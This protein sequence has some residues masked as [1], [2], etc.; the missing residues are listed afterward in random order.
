MSPW[1]PPGGIRPPAGERFARE[2]G[3]VL[4]GGWELHAAQATEVLLDAIARSDG[5]RAS[6]LQELRKTTVRDGLLG[7]FRFDRHG[8]MTPAKITISRVTGRTP[9]TTVSRRP[10]D[11][12]VIDR[13]VTVP[14][15]LAG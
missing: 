1:R 14:E 4:N 15:D 3:E 9:E 10:L 13:V 6:V 7:D 2:F 5:T 8:D 12:T 11:G